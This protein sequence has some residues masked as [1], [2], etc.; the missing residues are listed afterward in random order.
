M[1]NE[2][3]GKLRLLYIYRLLVEESD[4]N[5]TLSTEQIR[6]RLM[7]RYGM[8]AH[9]VTVGDD[10]KLLQTAGVEIG[11]IESTQNKYWLISRPLEQAEIKILIDAVASSKVIT[12]KRSRELIQSLAKAGSPF[13]Q[14]E[15]VRNIFPEDR[16]KSGNESILYN[17]DA[18]NRA[19]NAKKKISFKYFGFAANKRRRARNDGQPYFFSPWALVWNGDYYYMVGWSDKHQGIGSFRIDRIYPVPEVLE[20]RY[21]QPPKGFKVSAYIKSNYH[22]FGGSVRRVELLCDGDVMDSIIDRFGYDVET[23]L[24]DDGR[25]TASADVAVNSVFYGWVFGFGGK[26]RIVSPAEAADGYR[27]MVKKALEEADL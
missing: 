19:I 3:T 27:E 17:V 18:V 20:E 14:D 11:K 8:E 22:M 2:G 26:V 24:L 4:E 10:I 23:R 6:A 7:E 25:F 21:V 12:K 9:R 13:R 1:R 15:L 16:I 5:H